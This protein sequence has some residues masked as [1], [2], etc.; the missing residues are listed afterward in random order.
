RI[1]KVNLVTGTQDSSTC[2]ETRS[3]AG[4]YDGPAGTEG[5][6]L[7]RAGTQYCELTDDG[8]VWSGRVGAVLPSEESCD[9]AADEDCDG[10]IDEGCTCTLGTS[11]DC[12][13]GP[14]GTA[15]VGECRAGTQ[16]C[17]GS[18]ADSMWGDCAG[19]VLPLGREL[20]GRARR[21]LRR[22]HRL[23]RLRL[24]DARGVLHAL[25]RE[26]ADR[27]ARR[28]D[29]L[30]GGSLRQHGLAGLGHD[31]HPLGVSCAAPWTRCSR[32]SRICRSAS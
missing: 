28:G 32:A 12:Y 24:R 3:G 7:C 4:R 25:R 19:A 10:H 16:V 18:S 22:R 1:A 15:G 26:R 21:G 30:R 29:P 14:A 27:P 11:R 9:G 5:V 23:C 31:P 2:R 17:V 20:H 13:G 8:S 6:G